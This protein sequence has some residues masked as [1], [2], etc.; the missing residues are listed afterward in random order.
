MGA[1]LSICAMLGAMMTVAGW[2]EMPE[3]PRGRGDRCVEPTD[4]M[5]KNHMEFIL[6][7]RDLTVRQG[8]R[9]S[10]YS[11]TGCIACHVQTDQTGAFIPVDAENQF[12]DVCHSYAG[13]EPDCFTCHAAKPDLHAAPT[14]LHQGKELTSIS[15]FLR[16][17]Q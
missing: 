12:C 7:Q 10:R 8:I 1:V 14:D 4:V 16:Q 5:R 9:T 13:L 11:L 2:A 3:I 17:L 15:A 6:H